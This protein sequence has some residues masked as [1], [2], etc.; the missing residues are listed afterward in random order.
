MQQKKGGK[1]FMTISREKI[2]SRQNRLVVD[3]VKLSER[4]ARVARGEFRFDGKKLFGEAVAFGVVIRKILLAESK[5]QRMLSE[6]EQYRDAEA[7]ADAVVY[8]LSDDVFAKVSEEQAP[9]GILCVAS[10][11]S[12]HATGEAGRRKLLQV[13]EMP[14]KS[15][16]LLE[17][18]RDPGNVGTILRSASAFGIGC[19]AI[20]SD[21]A[22]IYN[23]KT[24]RGA[25]GALFRTEI[26]VFDDITE[27]VRILKR[28][29][30]RVYAAALD[31][32]A[33]R[34]GKRTLSAGD[35]VMVGN[36]GH[37]LS[38]AAIDAAGQSLYIPM[39]EGSESLNAAIAASVILWSLYGD[40]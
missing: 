28:E 30:H 5:A 17:S 39:E 12:F 35:C 3:T 38:E 6:I 4:K 18:V 37:G 21:C 34:L 40:K 16:L 24:I 33:V 9:E 31:P 15:V 2:T 1:G 11:P 23:P 29:G 36:E 7:L 32:D 25:M 26:A 19:V 22:D 14:L 8:I 27:A 10:F 13:A 20:S